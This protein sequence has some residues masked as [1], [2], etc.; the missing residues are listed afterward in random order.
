[1]G[2]GGGGGGDGDGKTGGGKDGPGG[3]GGRH[4]GR[5]GPGKRKPR[6]PDVGWYVGTYRPSAGSYSTDRLVAI[7][8]HLRALGWSY[9]QI[10]ENVY[11]PFII[12]GPAAWSDTWG[13]PRFGPAPG[14][15]RT[16]Q[17]QDVFCT[18]GDPVI[19]SERGTVDFGSGGLGGKVAR[20]Y[21]SDGSYWYYAHLAGFNPEL[22]SGSAVEPGDVLGY[23]GTSGNAATTAP[24]VHFGWY[25]AGGARDPH[26]TLI[27]WLRRAESRAQALV[28]RTTGKRV[29]Q[30]DRLTAERFFGDA[31]APDLSE[32]SIAAESLWASGTSPAS[33]TLGLAE[34]A[35]Q[36]ALASPGMTVSPSPGVRVPLASSRKVAKRHTSVRGGSPLEQSD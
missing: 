21:R 9:D 31:F 36:A 22:A 33:G 17:G 5:K 4:G 19:A 35:L 18:Y 28:M 13:A 20:L 7:G 32:L 10:I 16:H 30:I 25:G 27:D 6:T 23:C 1:G 11:P 8:T 12:A 24:H 14:Q 29:K 3:K 2:G 34:S 26:E 15:V